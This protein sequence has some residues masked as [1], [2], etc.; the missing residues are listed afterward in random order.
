MGYRHVFLLAIACV[1]LPMVQ[2]EAQLRCDSP[3]H[4]ENLVRNAV[5]MQLAAA[6]HEGRWMYA[7]RNEKNGTAIREA[8]IQ[9]NEGT[10][11]IVFARNGKRVFKGPFLESSR[12][13]MHSQVE[14]IDRF[15]G[16]LLDSVR[17]R[18]GG[19]AEGVQTVIFLPK[20]HNIPTGLRAR[21]VAAMEGTIRIDEKTGR[22]LSMQGHLTREVTYAY[23]LLGRVEPGGTASARWGPV[24]GGSWKL[25]GFSTQGKAIAL[26]FPIVKNWEEDR[27]DFRAVP[28]TISE[29]A[30]AALLEHY[31]A[32]QTP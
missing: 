4:A 31:V 22:I 21:V 23:G 32:A 10:L 7:V 27:Y 16:L 24:A 2:A 29:T 18:C 28:R 6:A 9:I 14:E 15:W 12:E 30:A 11:A 13:H 17:F 25:T 20:R 1:L 26:F 19:E 3:Y 8:R 5:A